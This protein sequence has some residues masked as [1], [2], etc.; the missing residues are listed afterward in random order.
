MK[1]S[2]NN[3]RIE[4]TPRGVFQKTMTPTGGTVQ[5]KVA[6]L[7]RLRAIGRRESDGATFGQV[8]FRTIHGNCR[9]QLFPM[10]KFLPENRREIRAKL[11]DLGYRWPEDNA[12]ANAI[13]NEVANADP[14]QALRIVCAPGWYGSAY[15][16]PGRVFAG[17][18][19][20][21]EILI[22]PNSTADIGAFVCG[23]GSLKGWQTFVAAPSRKSR[24]L[25]LSIA[26]AFAAP[27]LRPLG[28]DS[29]GINWFGKTSDGKS[30]SAIIAA[31]VP[32]LMGPGGLAAWANSEPAIEAL[33]YGH[34]DSVMPLDQSADGNI[35]CHWSERHKCWRF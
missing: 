5:K 19:E 23:P 32:G 16:L 10:S 7:V 29:F 22:D 8:R 2:K 12:L 27:F 6:S 17:G 30:L 4:L 3:A 21:P 26:A 31:S 13:L 35:K 33:A 11:A 15:V 20:R 9:N 18:T 1:Q 28:L 14:K 25:R 24:C 34:R